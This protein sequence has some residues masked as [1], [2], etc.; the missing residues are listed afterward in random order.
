[1]GGEAAAQDHISPIIISYFFL[2]EPIAKQVNYI[3]F[4]FVPK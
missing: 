4:Y 2:Y 3:A 1:M